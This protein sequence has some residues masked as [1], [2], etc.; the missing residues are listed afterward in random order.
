MAARA[1]RRFERFV[2][3][4]VFA[5]VAWIIERRVLKAIR[6]RGLTPPAKGSISAQTTSELGRA[7]P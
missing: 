6:K 7:A 2:L 3:G 4:S 1:V 5:V